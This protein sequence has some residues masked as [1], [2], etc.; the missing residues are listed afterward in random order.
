MTIQELEAN[1]EFRRASS[2]AQAEVRQLWFQRELQANPQSQNL[3]RRELSYLA[4]QVMSRGPVLATDDQ[5]AQEFMALAEGVKTGQDVSQ[6]M[7]T[8]AG[9]RVSEDFGILSFIGRNVSKV[10]GNELYEEAEDEVVRTDRAKAYEHFMET[11]RTNEQTR[12][13][14][15]ATDVIVPFAGLMT[16]ILLTRGV[17]GAALQGLGTGGRVAAGVITKGTPWVNA[18]ATTSRVANWWLT[19]GAPNMLQSGFDAITTTISSNLNDDYMAKLMNEPK[20]GLSWQNL[21]LQ[22]GKEFAFDYAFFG[23]LEFVAP[24]FKATSRAFGSFTDLARGNTIMSKALDSKS[25]DDAIKQIETGN[26]SPE[27]LATL[28]PVE[29]ASVKFASNFHKV[30]LQLGALDEVGQTVALA[31]AKGFSL[32]PKG[33]DIEAKLDM[34]NNQ[35]KQ[36][37]ELLTKETAQ[38]GDDPVRVQATTRRYTE[39]LKD[40]RTQRNEAISGWE[41]RDLRGEK[42]KS[43]GTYDDAEQAFV[44]ISKKIDAELTKIGQ[45]PEAGTLEANREAMFKV[46]QV[47]ELKVTNPSKLQPDE[48]ARF[49]DV[50]SPESVTRNSGGV[51][52]KDTVERFVKTLVPKLDPDGKVLGNL[53]V[54]QVSDSTWRST[55]EI[56]QGDELLIPARLGPEIR[57][58]DDTMFGQRIVDALEKKVPTPEGKQ[59]LAELRNELGARASRGATPTW[60]KTQL[61]LVDP[62]AK[63][64]RKSDGSLELLSPGQAPRLYANEQ[65][66]AKK[67]FDDAVRAGRISGSDYFSMLQAH[68]KKNFNVDVTEIS[69]GGITRVVAKTSK[70]KIV[71]QASSVD[72]LI[73]SKPYLAPKLPVELAPYHVVSGDGVTRV[74]NQT[75]VGTWKDIL[76]DLDQFTKPPKTPNESVLVSQG[77]DTTVKY[78][79]TKTYFEVEIPGS[80]STL[81]FK[82]K[83][84]LEGFIQRGVDTS[85]SLAY[86]A[87]SKGVQMI[88]T[89]GEWLLRNMDGNVVSAKNLD[90]VQTYLRGLP[91]NPQVGKDLLDLSPEL[92]EF[93]E[94]NLQDMI[95]EVDSSLKA[96]AVDEIDVAINRNLKRAG[97]GKKAPGWMAWSRITRLKPEV[98]KDIAIRNNQTGIIANLTRFENA[99]KTMQAKINQAES[100]VNRNWQGIP[101]TTRAQLLPLLETAP[102]NWAKKLDEIQ[103]GSKNKIELTRELEQA[104]NGHRTLL[105]DLFAKDFGISAWKFQSEYLPRVR[106]FVIKNK[107]DLLRGMQNSQ[108]VEHYLHKRLS[109][110]FGEANVKW[111]A[112]NMRIQELAE[113]VSQTDPVDLTMAY[114]RS[115]YKSRYLAP[116][117]DEFASS[118][119]R[120]QSS[121]GQE[122]VNYIAEYLNDS[123]SWTYDAIGENLGEISRNF[124]LIL[125]NKGL[126]PKGA[127]D[128]HKDFVSTLQKYTV[129]ATMSFRPSLIFRNTHQVYTTG[130]LYMPVD[131]IQE[132]SKRALELMKNP[133]VFAR[134]LVDSGLLKSN[135]TYL[136]ALTKGRG[137]I[138]ALNRHGMS[139][140][141]NS[142][143]INRTTIYMGI[144]A[145][146][147]RALGKLAK[148]G[149]EKMDFKQVSR[150]LELDMLP[151]GDYDQLVKIW[152]EQGDDAAKA[153]HASRVVE[154]SQFTYDAT[155]NPQLMRGAIGRMFG[156]FGHYPISY[157]EGIRKAITNRPAEA[158]AI[159]AARLG[160]V[161]AAIA[162][163]HEK[164]GLDPTAY[165]PQGQMFFTGGP[166]FDFAL[167]ALKSMDQGFE[168]QQA[169][170]RLGRESLQMFMPFSALGRSTTQA[171]NLFD[172]GDSYGGFLKLMSMPY[173][174]FD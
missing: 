41:V 86:I 120:V 19:R 157:L 6:G 111:F 36:L 122:N 152:R 139:P 130:S 2:R 116:A 69:E 70:G 143:T 15:Q 132:G 96:F 21:A 106:D 16:D 56:I 30:D 85:T 110:E 174:G 134:K 67:L 71:D 80:N 1:P 105:E 135:V 159:T 137:V 11:M 131:A 14:A 4:N 66:L 31:R 167:T 18:P 44:G 147:D 172:E 89:N 17:G 138:D 144:E 26:F 57:G 123:M 58:V 60:I 8:F 115:G 47:S 104:L 114:V 28:S 128:Q 54:R 22:Y 108:N 53:K 79:R 140:Y 102:E 37:E 161:T 145:L 32:V 162:L 3:D 146:W 155:H 169:R 29:R 150:W 141:F 20:T 107:D 49:R 10:F 9:Q 164:F 160:T 154:L 48:L 149:P 112:Q 59:I 129:A 84:E 92:N 77:I 126:L 35:Q 99:K 81:T 165:T 76:D 158:L 100:L 170:A 33:P 51:I 173:Q 78:N 62:Q 52:R 119:R 124:H 61:K 136:G 148:L 40:L 127:A 166:H 125:E 118:V 171:M 64:T 95:S 156:M 93:V 87:S 133:D 65:M 109:K 121:I 12:G 38:F 34:L 68:A 75:M 63:L 13:M 97:L 151:A 45:A 103:V 74:A 24:V 142:D 46:S 91:Q 55:K 168:G 94:D 98:I 42:P 101:H 113:F 90:Q 5:R 25:L 39:A 27:A 153:F 43:I 73:A 72:A 7:L 163:T 50:L 82:N 117:Y 23:A 83:K 88:W